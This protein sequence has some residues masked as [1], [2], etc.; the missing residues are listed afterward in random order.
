MIRTTTAIALCLVLGVSAADE[1]RDTAKPDQEAI[2]A[3]TKEWT[4]HNTSD[5]GRIG[6]N[7]SEPSESSAGMMDALQEVVVLCATQPESESLKKEWSSFLRN[8]YTPDMN[9]N[10]LIDDV[11][12]RADAFQQQ[13]GQTKSNSTESDI[14]WSRS[15]TM[16]LETAKAS[17]KGLRY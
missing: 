5:P 17:V 14:D 2:P 10:A 3:E 13:Y 4:D 15:R 8:H 12:K 16:L 6:I 1:D 7:I 11:V 9:I